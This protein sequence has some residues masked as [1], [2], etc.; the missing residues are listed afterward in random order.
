MLIYEYY[1]DCFGIGYLRIRKYRSDEIIEIR[2][3]HMN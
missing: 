3:I 1:K 2:K